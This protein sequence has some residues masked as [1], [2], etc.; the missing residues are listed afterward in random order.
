MK[1]IQFAALFQP[2]IISCLG[3]PFESRATNPTTYC[4]PTDSCWP[5]TAQWSAFN[6]TLG[7]K[8]I[9]VIPWSSP[10]YALPG[11]FN[12]AQCSAVENSYND[13]FARES[14]FGSAQSLN[15]ESCGEDNCWLQTK[16]PALGGF[17]NLV[18][19]Q[20]RLASFAVN[21]AA[22]TAAQD[23][24]STIAFAIAHGVKLSIKNTGHEYLGRSTGQ[25]TLAIWTYNLKDMTV[26]TQNPLNGGG[27]TITIGSGAVARDVYKAAGDAGY[28]IT[29]GAFGSVGVG[30]GFAQGG[31]HGRE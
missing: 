7:G 2:L 18:C 11:P 28:S 19:K 10:C 24:A 29:L 13:G 27:P 1:A 8:L 16:L 30:G 25:Y 4:T 21:L 12:S 5:T 22:P 23:I 15:W 14:V 17:Q 6:S 9:K 26:Q 31:G 3:A 20:G